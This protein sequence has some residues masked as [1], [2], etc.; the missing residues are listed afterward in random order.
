MC[1]YAKE[2]RIRTTKTD[3]VVY[4]SFRPYSRKGQTTTLR[5]PYRGTTWTLGEPK[6]LS[7]FGREVFGQGR[8]TALK[9]VREGDSVGRGFHAYLKASNAAEEM[10]QLVVRCIIPKGT[11]YILGRCGEI[12]ALALIP[13]KVLR[14]KQ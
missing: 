14:T 9:T 13:Q 1:L 2:A 3:R 6:V 4:K 10:G 5:S 11:K 7:S 12:V 8:S